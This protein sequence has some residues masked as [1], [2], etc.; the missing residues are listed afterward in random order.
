VSL[1]QSCRVVERHLRSRSP[2]CPR[3]AQHSSQARLGEGGGMAAAAAAAAAA[4]IVSRTAQAQR[5]DELMTACQPNV[6]SASTHAIWPWLSLNTPIASLTSN[7]T[8]AHALLLA[9]CTAQ[10]ASHSLVRMRANLCQ[11]H[12]CLP[13]S[14]PP[15]NSSLH[16]SPG[17]VH[18]E[19]HPHHKAPDEVGQPTPNCKE[20]TLTQHMVPAAVTVPAA[21]V[22]VGDRAAAAEAAAQ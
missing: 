21:A 14:P 19:E 2:C 10:A 3:H 1:C 5:E 13:V 18:S 17:H 15:P 4:A 6:T 11:V 12:L 22:E 8:K 9:R 20:H 16:V 7:S